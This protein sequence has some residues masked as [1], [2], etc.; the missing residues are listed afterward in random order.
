VGIKEEV[1]ELDEASIKTF[2]GMYQVWHK[3]K[4]IA[5]YNSKTDAQDHANSLR[6]EVTNDGFKAELEDNKAK[7][8]G[9][10]K[11]PD[12]AKASVQAVKQ[13]SFSSKLT[14]LKE[15]V[16]SYLKGRNNG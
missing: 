9:T 5:S 16:R 14:S 11:Q 13:E 6:E 4:K 1:K 12:I 3:G 7:A 10:K 2:M 8:A 15:G